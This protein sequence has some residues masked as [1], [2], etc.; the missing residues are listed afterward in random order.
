MSR[1]INFLA[2]GRTVLLSFA[3]AAVF[4]L[5]LFP[6][7]A[8]DYR[9]SGDPDV[10]DLQM[11]FTKPRFTAILQQWIDYAGMGAIAAFRRTLLVLD[12]VFPAIYSVFLAGL[13]AWLS[14]ISRKELTGWRRAVIGLPFLAALFDLTENAIHYLL[15]GRLRTPA[16]LA[17]LPAVP[18]FIA[19]LLAAFKYVAIAVPALASV[20]TGLRMVWEAIFPSM[21]KRADR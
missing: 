3:L 7:A 8:H 5:Y 1:V 2:A 12:I 13:F 15:L 4:S 19:S 9:A 18:I 10:I 11:A 14:R 20:F 16:D 21:G 17:A 6:K